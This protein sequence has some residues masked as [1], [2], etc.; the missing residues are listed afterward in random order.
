[1]AAVVVVAAVDVAAVAVAADA[2]ATR[3]RTGDTLGR[4]AAKMAPRGVL[5]AAVAWHIMGLACEIGN[6]L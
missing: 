4:W 6:R 5:C 3:R 2:D 1:M